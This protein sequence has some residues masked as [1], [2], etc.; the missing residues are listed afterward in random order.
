MAEGG[1]EDSQ[2]K[3]EEPT[4][5]RIEKSREE[6][7][8]PRSKE[9]TTMAVLMAG[10]AGLL[11]FGGF[12]G[13]ALKSIMLHSFEIP[14]EAMF[15]TQQMALYLAASAKE[16][17]ISLIPLFVLILIAAFA[18]PLA[19]GGLLWSNKAFAPKFSR[20]NPIEGIK[21]MFSMHSL[22]ELL[23][24]IAKV[25]VVMV[26]AVVYMKSHTEE[27]L[28]F[29]SMPAV[30]AM[31]AVVKMMGWAFFLFSCS[32]I[33]IALVDVPFQIYDHN[34]KLKMSMQEIKD[35]FKETEGKPEVKQRVRRLQHEM[36]QRRMLQDVPDADVVI[37]N[38]THYSVALKY[39][40]ATMDAPVLLAKGGDQIA[41]KIREIAAEHKVEMIQAPALT[42]SVFY[43]TEVGHP[44]PE[45]LYV[46][47][48]QVLAYVFQ[49]RAYRR[50]QNP[51]PRQPD[52]PIPDDMRHD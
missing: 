45:G 15:T 22:V 20:M 2:E 36:A 6:G 29:S 52:Y 26:F 46:A 33:I 30:P 39:D 19:I 1:G 37:T 34:K 32:M 12:I 51:K 7:Q 38:P 41:L 21:R 43:H 25:S 35:E 18:G 40:P 27:L 16:A 24:A 9:L 28:G 48:A 14:R 49:L 23:K 11:F 44:I 13:N 31:A 4:P 8:V 10:G 47:V 3:T 42:R 50:G 17:G 5:K